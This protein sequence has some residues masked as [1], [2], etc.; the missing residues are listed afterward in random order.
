MQAK[1]SL[2][3]RVNDGT[4]TFPQV[5]CLIHRKAILLPVK[6]NSDKRE[7]GSQDIIGFYARYPENGR[8]KIKP[9]GKDPVAAYT[10]FQQIEQNF[11]RT[12]K[13]LLPLNPEPEPPSQKAARD[14][15]TCLQKYRADLVTRGISSRSIAKYIPPCEDFVSLYTQAKASIDDVNKDDF[16]AYLKWMRSNLKRKKNGDPQHTYRNRT[17]YVNAFLAAFDIKPPMRMRDIKKPT[18]KRPWKYSDDVMNLLL[19]KAAREEK[20]LIHFML[21]TGFRDEEA[22]F[23]TWSDIDLKAGSINVHPKPQYANR[24]GLDDR[25]WRPKDSDYREQD[26][27][28]DPKFVKIMAERKQRMRAKDDDLI[29]P[30]PN[31]NPDIHLIKK[32]RRA[33]KRV[34]FPTEKIALHAFRRTFGTKIQKVYGIERA[35]IW[36]GHEDIA[37]TQRYIACDEMTTKEAQKKSA[38]AFAGIGD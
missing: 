3:A 35:R 34:D 16:M 32:V 17:Q 30:T 37:T 13:G 38:Q 20:D 5:P 26:I 12:Q 36:L 19:S 10:Q 28:L 15:R 2:L 6:R 11:A 27:V 14:I 25:G 1:V 24:Y 8:R 22:T 7:F 18:K 31:N 23:A 21:N 29:F 9:L 4:G 33:A